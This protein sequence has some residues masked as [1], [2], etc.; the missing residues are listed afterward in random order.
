MYNKKIIKGENKCFAQLRL[1]AID[2]GGNAVIGINLDYTELGALK[3]MIMVSAYGTAIEL[4]NPDVLGEAEVKKI[5]DYQSV[6][7]R[8][9]KLLAKKKEM[10]FVNF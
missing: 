2:L 3:G 1:K 5:R 4:N 10:S 8:H 6:L 9:K 7:N